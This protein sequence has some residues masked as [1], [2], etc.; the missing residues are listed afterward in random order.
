M[1]KKKIIAISVICAVAAI[2]AVTGVLIYMHFR[3]YIR[4]KQTTDNLLNREYEYTLDGKVEGMDLKLLGDSFEGTIK[5]QKGK[6]VVYGDIA[7]KDSDYLKIYA[8]MKGDIIFDAS[9]LIDQAIDTVADSIPFGKSLIESASSDVKI[10]YDQ[11]EYILN[12]DIKTLKDEGVSSDLMENVSH[13]KNG[14]YTLS[15]LKDKDIDEKDKLL[16]DD[17]YYFDIDLK[18]Y[19]TKLVVGIPKDKNDHRISTNIYADKITWSFTG[20][21]EIKTVE[22]IKMPE[23]TVSDK[24]IDVL[25]SLY[26]SYLEII[27]KS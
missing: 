7:Y 11:I 22:D 24:T 6:N 3:P 16:D 19:D 27:K 12:Q 13:R 20:E 26:S 15:L 1:N 9:P 8:D 10:S 18:D 17:A 14:G 23:A 5:G 4:L 25:K 21:Y 2:A